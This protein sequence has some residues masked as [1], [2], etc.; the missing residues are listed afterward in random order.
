M[1]SYCGKNC[2]ECDRKEELECNGCKEWQTSC[3]SECEIAKCCKDK[4]HDTCAT[5]NITGCAKL[6][7]KFGVPDSILQARNKALEEKEEL[8]KKSVILGKWL[9]LAFWLIIP[10]CVIALINTFIGDT[11]SYVLAVLE[12]ISAALYGVFIIKA[13][14]AQLEY[15]L[16][17][18]LRVIISCI[19]IASTIII[20]N[21]EIGAYSLLILIPMCVLTFI[22]TK[23]EYNTHAEVLYK[24]NIELSQK[25]SKLW[26][27]FLISILLI[28]GG[29]IFVFIIPIIGSLATI[30][31]AV[32]TVIVS[33]KQ[34]IYLHKTAK[35][36]REYNN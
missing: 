1:Y 35:I 14:E 29:A 18:I 19:N 9:W 23:R 16:S 17:G 30:A 2:L 3:S 8:S 36:F 26:E 15:K 4:N 5:C 31:G 13:S 6:S 28:I 20:D 21:F 12:S 34:L 32:V 24:V 7:R 10:N 33:I 27:L 22:I 11:V 25:W